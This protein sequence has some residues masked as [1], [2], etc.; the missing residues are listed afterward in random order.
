ME[1]KIYTNGFGEL[2]P[3]QSTSINYMKASMIVALSVLSLL[4]YK[5]F[6]KKRKK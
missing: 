6:I 2:T 3:Y 5:S 1:K 4:G